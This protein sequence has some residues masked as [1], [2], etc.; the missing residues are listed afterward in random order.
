MHWQKT[1]QLNVSENLEKEGKKKK[2]LQD[3]ILLQL[4]LSFPPPFFTWNLR[5]IFLDT[6]YGPGKKEWQW[7]AQMNIT[8][9]KN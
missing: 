8:L 6:A 7:R 3:L 9:S 4:L 2:I 5:L 1:L